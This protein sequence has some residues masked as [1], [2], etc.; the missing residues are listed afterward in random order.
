MGVRFIN[1][2][3]ERHSQKKPA[4]DALAPPALDDQQA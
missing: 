3:R 2:R 4:G 1:E